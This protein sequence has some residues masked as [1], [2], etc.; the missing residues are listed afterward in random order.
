MAGAVFSIIFDD[1]LQ[2]KLQNHMLRGYFPYKSKVDDWVWKVNLFRTVFFT[3]KHGRCGY[4]NHCY[5]GMSRLLQDPE[6][7]L[8]ARGV[9]T[10]PPAIATFRRSGSTSSSE[11]TL[12]TGRMEG[13]MTTKS[14]WLTT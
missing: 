13:P 5:A 12:H 14:P 2:R 3:G 7:L 11:M 1:D 10:T 4:T 6:F 8:L 9:T